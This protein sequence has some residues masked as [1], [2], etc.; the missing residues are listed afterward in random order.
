VQIGQYIDVLGARRMLV[1]LSILAC[2]VAAGVLAW[3]RA[4]TYAAETQLFIST[5]GLSDEVGQAFEAERYAQQRAR[6]YAEIISS[7]RGAEAVIDELGLSEGVHAVQDKIRASVAPNSVVI[8]VTVRD[9]SPELAKS[10]AD[11]L[12]DQLPRLAD[13]LERPEEGRRGS[14]VRVIAAAPAALPTNPISPRKPIYLALGALFGLV[15]GI[16]GAVLRHALDYRIRDGEDASVTAGAAVLGRIAEHGREM[17]PVM[18]SDPLSAGAEG[19]RALRANLEALRA[20]HDLRSVVVS[21]AV[22]AEGKTD[23]VANLG[24]A[25]AQARERVVVVDANLRSPRLGELLEVRSSIGLS[26]LLAIGAPVEL[27]LRRQPT[28]PPEAAPLEIITSGS[29]RPNPSELLDSEA[30]DGALQALTERFDLVI[31]DSPALL[32]VADAA[33]LAR[34]AS[35]VILVARAGSTST[36]ELQAARQAL[37]TVEG[38]MLGVVLNRVPEGD[39]RPYPAEPVPP[40]RSRSRAVAPAQADGEGGL[41]W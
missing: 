35:G 1:A 31:V 18:M 22:A 40:P 39:D 17:P 25:L 29:R 2:T 14:P 8:D 30:F 10:I 12:D 33:A 9:R 16:G 7:P 15:V 37:R 21:S 6:T 23:V 19:Y 20:E 32:A 34:R 41:K 28:A 38:R 36:D 24:I 26:D 4:P 13:A 11:V 3:T 5:P 27:A